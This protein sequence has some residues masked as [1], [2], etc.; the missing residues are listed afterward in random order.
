[1]SLATTHPRYFVGIGCR[2]GCSEVALRELLERTL[3]ANAIAIEAIAGI[4]TIDSK[5][6]EAGLLALATNLKLPVHFFSA[7]EL[8]EFSARVDA[9]ALIVLLETGAANIAEASALALAEKQ[10]GQPAE[11]FIRKCKSSDCTLALAVANDFAAA[12]KNRS[13]IS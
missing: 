10:T 9:A 6:D 1:M 3:R 8:N 13:R 7:Q 5:R 2:R 4:A 12:N 11:L